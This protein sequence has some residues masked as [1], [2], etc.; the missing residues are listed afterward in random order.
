MCQFRMA[1]TWK[2]YSRHPGECRDPERN[3]VL[4]LLDSGIRQ[5]NEE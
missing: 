4:M 1:L 3:N 2:N 5:H